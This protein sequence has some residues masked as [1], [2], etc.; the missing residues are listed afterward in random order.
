MILTGRSLWYANNWRWPWL[1]ESLGRRQRFRR[2]GYLGLLTSLNH[3]FKINYL[4]LNF[5]QTSFVTTA[6]SCCSCEQFNPGTWRCWWLCCALK[7]AN[8]W[9]IF[10]VIILIFWIRPIRQH[11]SKK[12]CIKNHESWLRDS[13]LSKDFR[14]NFPPRCVVRL[15]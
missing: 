13:S 3:I 2:H 9:Q 6:R 11:M 10:L 7:H 1:W 8:L 14:C 4:I 15:N 5:V 12:S